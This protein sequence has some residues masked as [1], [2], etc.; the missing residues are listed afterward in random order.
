MAQVLS[1]LSTRFANIECHAVWSKHVKLPVYKYYV[2]RLVFDL[3]IKN[4]AYITKKDPLNKEARIPHPV[5]LTTEK[6]PLT[7]TFKNIDASGALLTAEGKLTVLVRI[8]ILTH[9]F[10][11][12]L[13]KY[14]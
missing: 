10:H 9:S 14:V 2:L 8:S 13:P 4:F 6:G 1:L 7:H 3:L 12:V 5:V 11:L